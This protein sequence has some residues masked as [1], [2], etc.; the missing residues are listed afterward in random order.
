MLLHQGD[1]P[2]HVVL[3]LSGR[4]KALLHL[5]DGEVLLLGV[6][7]AGEILGVMGVL[8]GSDRS[9]T[10]IAL[11]V[12]VTRM[13]PAERFLAFVRSPEEQLVL[14]RRAMLRIREVE[15][16]RAEIA[17]LPARLRVVH[18]LL[19]LAV[20]V[21]GT[22]LEVKLTQSEI[23]HAVGLS[24]SVVA[25]ELARLRERKIV[26]TADGKVVINDTAMLRALAASGPGNV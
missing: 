3:L 6:R 4:V 24:R 13:L 9:A 19:R 25:A 11:D 18:A 12:C 7:G 21:P 14:L 15:A 1:A 26:T 2:S 10:V 20:P 8:S 17:T 16:W 22:P 5:A 23:G